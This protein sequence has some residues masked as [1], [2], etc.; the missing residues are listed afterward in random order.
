MKKLLLALLVLA[1]TAA[2]TAQTTSTIE[3]TVRDPAGAAMADA[4][5]TIA[6]PTGERTVKSDQEGRYRIVAVPPGRYTLTAS[7][8][9]FATVT[10]T[11]LP[12]DLNRTLV[13]DVGL[14]AGSIQQTIEVTAETP[15]LDRTD[16][17]DGW[18]GHPRADREAAGQRPRLPRP[19]AARSRRHHQPRRR[20]GRRHR[21]AGAGRARRQRHPTGRRH[22]QPQRVQRRS[23]HPVQSGLDLRVRG[24][25]RRLQGGVRA[26]QRRRHQRRHQE[27]PERLARHGRRVLARRFARLLE[28]PGGRRGCAGARPLDL[29]ANVGGPLVRDRVFVFASAGGHRRGSPAQLHDSA[30][31]AAVR[32]RLRELVRRAH[33]RRGDPAVRALRRADRRPATGSPSR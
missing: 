27:R 23:G 5:V 12:V 4:T 28:Q 19:G 15:L 13:L 11:E 2:V 33:P 18:R 24:H 16:S 17:G 32:P 21:D 7:R 30:G 25:H 6:G 31:H 1:S 8:E 9:G 22:A 14:S 20:R 10:L 3:G 26:R 29:A